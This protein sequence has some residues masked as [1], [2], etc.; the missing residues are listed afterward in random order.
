MNGLNCVLYLFLYRK[1]Q[2]HLIPEACYKLYFFHFFEIAVACSTLAS[3][4]LE[5]AAFTTEKNIERWAASFYLRRLAFFHGIARFFTIAVLSAIAT[6]H[7]T[8]AR[9]DAGIAAYL[10]SLTWLPQ[11]IGRLVLAASF[12]MNS[13][14]ISAMF[15]GGGVQ[16]LAMEA[17]AMWETLRTAEMVGLKKEWA[18]TDNEHSN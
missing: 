8:I 3:L 16:A 15:L 4:P 5:I 10:D 7:V 11:V 13:F 12:T 6:S 14:V 18:D 1:L 17:R 2:P 9:R